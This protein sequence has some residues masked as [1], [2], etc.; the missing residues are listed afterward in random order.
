[1]SDI[2][3]IVNFY[4]IVS[5]S[6]PD[7]TKQL[8]NAN[9]IKTTNSTTN[10]WRIIFIVLGIVVVAFVVLVIVFAVKAKMNQR[11]DEEASET[12]EAENSG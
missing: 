1:M 9:Q 5:A 6:C 7:N 10:R 3:K 2:C 4:G 11:S 8:T 12:T